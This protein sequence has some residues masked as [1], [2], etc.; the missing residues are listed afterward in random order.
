MDTCMVRFVRF[1]RLVLYL[2][3]K[4]SRAHISID[5]DGALTGVIH[6]DDDT[7][8]AIMFEVG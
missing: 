5:D 2:G 7:N 8:D 3:A 6:L 4:D 1:V